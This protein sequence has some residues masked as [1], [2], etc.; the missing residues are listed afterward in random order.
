LRNEHHDE[1]VIFEINDDTIG[2]GDAEAPERALS[3]FLLDQRHQQCDWSRRAQQERRL[4]TQDPDD[5]A[6][7]ES[8]LGAA[9]H[10]TGNHLVAQKHFESSLGHARTGS[11][12]RAGLHLFNHT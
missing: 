2:D 11:R 12:F 9:S 1:P 8:M 7:A 3:I 6:L 10:L 5:L 4:K